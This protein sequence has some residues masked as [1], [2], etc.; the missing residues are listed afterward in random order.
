M[1][2]LRRAASAAVKHLLRHALLYGLALLAVSL[3]TGLA[4]GAQHVY[5]A[6]DVGPPPA[7]PLAPWMTQE[8][9]TAFTSMATAAGAV[10]LGAIKFVQVVGEQG[11]GWIR[12]WR[13][14]PDPAPAVPATQTPPAAA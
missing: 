14:Q 2:H 9:M 4:H 5:A 3:I 10:L 8:W 6:I 1:T 13:G 7:P 12:A 11:R